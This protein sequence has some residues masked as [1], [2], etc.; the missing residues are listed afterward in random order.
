M[1][2]LPRKVCSAC[3]LQHDVVRRI[4][5]RGVG[6]C[7]LLFAVRAE[8]PLPQGEGVEVAFAVDIHCRIEGSMTFRVIRGVTAVFW[9]SGGF[10]RC[11]GVP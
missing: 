1:R 3:F 6:E 4:L 10:K 9:A 8:V 5:L 2:V 7:V 11:W